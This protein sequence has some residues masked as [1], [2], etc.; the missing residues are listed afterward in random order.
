[1]S[2]PIDV[3]PGSNKEIADKDSAS[4]ASL[5]LIRLFLPFALGYFLSYLFRIINAVIA[6]ELLADIAMTP[7]EIGLVTSTYLLCF[8]AFQL[9]LG[10][11]LDRYEP[12]RVLAALLLVAA[13]GALLF[14]GAQSVSQ[15]MLGRGLIGLGVSACLMAAFK[16]Y[17]VWFP[18][19]RLPLVNGLQLT[20]GGLG[21]LAAT[22]PVELVLAVSNWQTLFL[23]LA[24]L[25][26]LVSL[27]VF[28]VV[29]RH[30]PIGKAESLSEQ[31]LGT[32]QILTHREFYLR[33]P[34]G[35]LAQSAFAAIQGLWVG[36]W[37]KDV[38]GLDS[39]E[40]ANQLFTVAFGM[41]CGFLSLGWLADRLQHHGMTPGQVCFGGMTLFLL[42]Q[43]W[44]FAG[45]STT[46]AILWWLFGFFGT[47][48]TLMFAVLSQRFPVRQTGRGNTTLNLL[49]FLGAFLMQWGIGAVIGAL[50]QTE[51][52]PLPAYQLGFGIC[53]VLQ[54]L[55]LLWFLWGSRPRPLKARS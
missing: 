14:A 6:P 28:W 22:R 8:A 41:T 17:S 29:P 50:G 43:S 44:I 2:D 35:M 5:P 38:E 53:G 1:M 26:V 51:F 27:L 31:L 34:A 45:P 36:L 47:S 48:G 9:P 3:A 25:C 32:W 24:G 52:S 49:I 4:A 23:G 46:P 10:I 37:L 54:L 55:G 15:L 13:L 11:L 40:L 20:A 12:R 33:A 18:L 39:L 42:V 21:A 19:Q 30:Q 7:A 16:T